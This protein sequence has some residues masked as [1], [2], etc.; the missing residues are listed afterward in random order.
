MTHDTS[1]VEKS[2]LLLPICERFISI[3]GEGARC[4][5]LSYFLRVYHCNLRCTFCDTPYSFS[6]NQFEKISVSKLATD[7]N[8]LAH[9]RNV[10]ITGGEPCIYDLGPLIDHL[11]NKDI[12]IETNGTLIPKFPLNRIQWNVSPKTSNSGESIVD[13]S[14]QF[15]VAAAH[16][17][18]VIFKFVVRQKE[19]TIADLQEVTAL[20]QKYSIPRHLIYIMPEATNRSSLEDGLES[21]V[22]NV[23]RFQ[24]NFS[25]REHILIWNGK[26]EK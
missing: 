24:Y 26:K 14:L 10:V 22:D 16:E 20:A 18:S 3:Q 11:K 2:D 12:E 23:V 17:H 4:G 1:P 15:W 7:I 8:S 13:A 25:P 6:G 5:R 9:I 21:F 19:H